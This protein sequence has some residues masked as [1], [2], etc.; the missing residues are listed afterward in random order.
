[1]SEKMA[2]SVE[3]IGLAVLAVITTYGIVALSV[4]I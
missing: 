1:M 4:A 3:L 2:E